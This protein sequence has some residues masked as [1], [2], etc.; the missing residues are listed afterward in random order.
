[1]SRT[2]TVTLE[3]LA[4]PAGSNLA[5]RV[6]TWS[7]RHGTRF[8]VSWNQLRIPLETYIHREH[9]LSFPVVT[10]DR[11]E[12]PETLH[13]KYLPFR[14]ELPG[15]DDRSLDVYLHHIH[16]TSRI[17]GTQ[18]V[19]FAIALC[20]SL[21]VRKI[22]LSD[23][24]SVVCARG[25][26]DTAPSPTYAPHLRRHLGGDPYE[27]G[28]SAALDLSLFKLLD[29]GMT[30]YGRFGFRPEFSRVQDRFGSQ[31][32]LEN[33]L[34]HC[35]D[36]VGRMNV[37]LVRDTARR[38]LGVVANVIREQAYGPLC[39]VIRDRSRKENG[40]LSRALPASDNRQWCFQILEQMDQILHVLKPFSSSISFRQCLR[41]LFDKECGH[42]KVL[43][44][45]VL[46]GRLWRLQKGGSVIAQVDYRVTLDDLVYI[47]Q[48]CNYVLAL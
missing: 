37:G 8:I 33:R 23:V 46:F 36:Y 24:A 43:E 15:C 29:K 16:R 47:R 20:K 14:I 18:M 48:H 44:T 3:D 13:F 32:E 39:V 38:V 30:F 2:R 41:T 4:R 19:E 6:A 12:A 40:R 25:P 35:L 42:Y 10:Y 21:G 27:H 22:Y 11:N 17:S 45:F 31:K 5:Q 9:G 1:M 7:K 34:Q 28:R 26:A